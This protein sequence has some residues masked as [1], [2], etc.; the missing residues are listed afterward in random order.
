MAEE[1]WPSFQASVL[2]SFCYWARV[3]CQACAK[4]MTSMW[5]AYDKH[6]T[7]I[8]QACDKHMTSTMVHVRRSL[9]VSATFFAFLCTRAASDWVRMEWEVYAKYIPNI[10]QACARHTPSIFQ[11]YAKHMPSIFQPYAKHMPS[12]LQAYAKH[13]PSIF[14]AYAKHMPSIFQARTKHMPSIMVYVR[15]SLGALSILDVFSS[16]RAVPDWVRMEQEV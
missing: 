8:W 13:M 4:H 2:C 11:A 5:Q 15:R 9:G 12:I 16:S 1:P 3:I 14:Q 10:F 7:S 6:M